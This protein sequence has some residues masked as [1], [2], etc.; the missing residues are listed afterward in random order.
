MIL[1]PI[2][3]NPDNSPEWRTTP[4]QSPTP[5]PVIHAPV[6]HKVPGFTLTTP[7]DMAPKAAKSTANSDQS[8]K[9]P[10]NEVVAEV[11][12]TPTVTSPVQKTPV[13]P[14]PLT[15]TPIQGESATAVDV[16]TTA[17]ATVPSDVPRNIHIEVDT[18]TDTRPPVAPSNPVPPVV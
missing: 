6:P 13:T 2:L 9:R 18:V 14:A 7:T 11:P 16:Q 15:S 8:G 1:E 10:Q 4:V 17:L 5:S 3:N 12:M